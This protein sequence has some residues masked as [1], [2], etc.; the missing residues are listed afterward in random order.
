MLAGWKFIQPLRQIDFLLHI[1]DELLAAHVDLIFQSLP[2]AWQSLP[3][4]DELF[5]PINSLTA[6]TAKSGQYPIRIHT[7]RR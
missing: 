7:G 2:R 3:V 6:I 1:S 5:V 4:G